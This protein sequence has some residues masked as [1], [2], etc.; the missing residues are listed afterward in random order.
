MADTTPAAPSVT[1]PAQVPPNPPTPAIPA[2]Q[3]AS[4]TPPK[5][6][7]EKPSAPGFQQSESI[8]ALMRKTAKEAFSKENTD[9]K[10]LVV[11][12]VEKK[13]EPVKAEKP[14]EAKPKVPAEKTEP[15]PAPV[16]KDALEGIEPPEGASEKT[17]KDWKAFR[18]K[19][20]DEINRVKNER[21][22]IAAELATYK[23]STPADA[24]DIAKLKAELQASNDRLAVLDVTNHPDFRRQFTEPKA[25][26][27]AAAKALITDN[28]V[29][30]APDVSA[31][32]DKPRAEFSKAITEAAQKLPLFDQAD[33]MQNAREAYRLNA[34]EKSQ[35]SNAAELRQQLQAKAAQ[36]ER[37]A[38]E[39]SRTEFSTRVPEL[40]IPADATPERAA[41]IKTYNQAREAAFAEAERFTFG[42]AT[43]R[44]VANIATRAAALE[45][46]ASHVLPMTQ[47]DLKQATALISQ[48]TG[49]LAAIKNAK[50]A[51]SF[52]GDQA[53]TPKDPSK[54]TFHDA[55]EEAKRKG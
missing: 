55:M 10:E 53:P 34:E 40:P 1:P 5:A 22:A 6:A 42:K 33:F 7:I 36:Q 11:M 13:P 19:A 41:E 21:A 18:E 37:S 38:F 27:L 35:L 28:A 25:K 2:P 20:S 29:E 9:G 39:E 45:L 48:L 8:E 14:P 17:V 47:R 26:A 30:G 44:E 15:P 4:V 52:S 49:E 3:S 12:P 51:P 54:M 23:K 43:P 50:S 16:E 24:A 31:L 46:V 32:L